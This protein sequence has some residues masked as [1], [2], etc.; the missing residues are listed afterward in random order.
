M[1]NFIYLVLGIPHFPVIVV[2]ELAALFLEENLNF[3]ISLKRHPSEN[4]PNVT[5]TGLER[6]LFRKA[7]VY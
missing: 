4:C 2:I 1:M 5:S 6:S 7:L 3:Q